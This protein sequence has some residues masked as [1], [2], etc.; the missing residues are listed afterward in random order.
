MFESTT[1]LRVRYGETDQMGYVYHGNYASFFEMGRIDWL[2][3]LG[4]SYKDMENNGVMLPVYKLNTKFLK[5]AYYD[6]ELFIKT[7]IKEMP[8]V[9]ISFNYKI[10][11]QMDELI[12]TGETDL[13]FIN[14]KTNKPMRCPKYILKKLQLS[15]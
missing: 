4:I 14:K 1:K 10:Y 2:R 7:R 12:T 8:G 15:E 3:K 13:V 6:D 9:R 11:N 5:P